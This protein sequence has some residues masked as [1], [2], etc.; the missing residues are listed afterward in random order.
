M[1]R[2]AAA[3]ALLCLTTN[4]RPAVVDVEPQR[5]RSIPSINWTDDTGR[6]RQFSE[7]GGYP[8]VL[9]P[10]YTRCRTACVRNVDRLKEALANSS[11]DPRQ[12]RVL[13]FSFDPTETA[14]SLAKYRRSENIPLGWSLGAA[15]Q[16]DIDRLLSE[17]GVQVGKAGA[18]FA[19]PNI[20]LFIDSD[21]RIAK[22]IY[23]T[24]YADGDVDLAIKVAAGQSDWIG[25][26]GQVIYSVLL[27]A[28]SILCVLLC[29]YSLQLISRARGRY[30]VTNPS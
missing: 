29:Y 21:R 7:F 23:G 3:L 15:S 20:L 4:A 5:G 14:A 27:F 19:H 13:L 22:W 12:F 10:I 11:R 1:N 30:A 17:A 2:L 8:L 24:D 18:E 26:R 9:L 28:G 6:Q 16:A 25:Q